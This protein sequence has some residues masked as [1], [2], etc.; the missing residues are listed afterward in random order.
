MRRLWDRDAGLWTGADESRW[1]GWLDLPSAPPDLRLLDAL[2]RVVDTA[3]FRHL[4]LLGMGGSSLAPEVLG[5]TLPG[6]A[7]APVLHVLDSTD[8]AQIRR[9]ERA[10]NLSHTLCLVSSKSG[11][12]LETMLLTEYVLDRL[13]KLV[14]AAEVG[15]HFLAITDPGSALETM[16]RRL[17]FRAVLPGVPSV[18]GRFSAL[19]NFGLAPAAL[20]GLDVRTLVTRAAAM[21]DRCRPE[22]TADQNPGLRLG[23]ILGVA[24]RQGRDK[25][26]LCLP[27]AI[28]SLGSWL[29]QLLAESTGK[30]GHGVIPVAGEA[31]GAPMSYGRDRLFVSLRVA[32]EPD[33]DQTAAV[34]ALA[35]AGQPVVELTLADRYDVG[36]EFVRWQIA[37]A[38]CGSVLGVHPFDQPDVEAS[39]RVTRDLAAAYESAG[40]LPP[41]TPLAVDDTLAAH[42]DP[43][44]ATR[45]H[46]A[47]GE[48]AGVSGLVRAHLAR[49]R[50]GDY[51]A[52][53]AYLD[54]SPACEAPL[55]RLREEVRARYRVATSLGFGPRFL[56]STGQAFKGGPDSGVFLQVTCDDAADLPVPARGYTFGVIKAAQARGDL[57]VLVTRRRRVLRVHLGPDVVA[58]LERLTSLVRAAG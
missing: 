7:G 27:P 8:P 58:G 39:K 54:R 38:V 31:V 36:A 57:Q 5:L 40:A 10:L 15:A 41:E 47:A 1:L 32:S 3:G 28:D 23:L 34:A 56:H 9:V 13:R 20:G 55:Q 22:V 12:T 25:V 45:L 33:P 17:R 18:G 44:T 11:T 51:F 46:A 48:R 4:L 50:P 53:L 26:T 35:A 24:A 52:L 29:E 37:T 14:G 21:A 2:R 43:A 6:P 16:A 49:L 19:S 30:A 42:A